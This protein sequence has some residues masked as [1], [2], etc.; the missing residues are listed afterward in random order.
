MMEAEA[1]ILRCKRHLEQREKPSP[2]KL[3]KIL[4][5]LE[6]AEVDIDLLK[7]TEIGDIRDNPNI[8]SYCLKLLLSKSTLLHSFYSLLQFPIFDIRKSREQLAQGS[9]RWP[10]S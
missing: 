10:A 4:D 3:H 5:R 2:E 1:K 9:P 8:L 7:S 6:K